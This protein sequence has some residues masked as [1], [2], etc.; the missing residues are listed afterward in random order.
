MSSVLR[1]GFI[2]LSTSGW[3]PRAHL[4][5]LKQNSKYVI[6][7]VCNTSKA[8]AENA[9]KHHDLPTTTK[10]YSSYQELADDPE[11]DLV[12]VSVRTD[13]HGSSVRAA[14][15]KGKS[16]YVEW[17]L[18]K[19]LEEARELLDL[20]KKHGSKTMVG[21]QARRSPEVNKIKQI[22]EA[23]TIGKVLSSSVTASAGNFG[24]TEMQAMEYFNDPKVGGNIF[25]IHFGHSKD[26]TVA[27]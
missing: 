18:G 10:A 19:D 5:Y 26:T 25:S 21:L 9:I 24:A 4:P 13:Y 16:A 14:L 15:E 2:G 11:V 6:T 22:L 7:G 23:G 1:V 12:V 17:P 3:A 8:S 20:A 27:G